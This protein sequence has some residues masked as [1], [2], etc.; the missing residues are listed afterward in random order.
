MAG[1]FPP[2]RSVVLQPDPKCN[3]SWGSGLQA[4]CCPCLG[5]RGL[6][7]PEPAGLGVS[8][9]PSSPVF[10]ARLGVKQKEPS[11]P[12][13]PQDAPASAGP[14]WARVPEWGQQWGEGGPS[15]WDVPVTQERV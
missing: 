6:A 11:W 10:D 2:P 9:L 15:S 3:L 5:R 13:G 14:G 4:R 8:C 1:R 12:S 7:H